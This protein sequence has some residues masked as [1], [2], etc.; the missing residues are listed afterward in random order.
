[1]LLRSVSGRLDVNEE[2]EVIVETEGG[3]EENSPIAAVVCATQASG[4]IGLTGSVRG[5]VK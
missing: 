5:M 3:L 4:S 2:A 1:M